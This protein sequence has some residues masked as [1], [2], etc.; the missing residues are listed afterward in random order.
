MYYVIFPRLPVRQV[1]KEVDVWNL[2]RRLKSEPVDANDFGLSEKGD[3]VEGE[4]EWWGG[5]WGIQLDNKFYSVMCIY[6]FVYD[7]L[8]DTWDK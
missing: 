1:E 6:E 4:V 2:S 3:D 7:L 5:G 8:V